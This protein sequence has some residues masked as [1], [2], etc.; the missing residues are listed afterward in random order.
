M[1]DDAEQMQRVEIFGSRAQ[2]LPVEPFGFRQLAGLMMT[3]RP[4]RAGL[5]R[6]GRRSRRSR[7]A[8]EEVLQGHDAGAVPIDP[9]LVGG[10]LVF[11]RHAPGGIA[12]QPHGGRDIA[13]ERVGAMV[14]RTPI[15]VSTAA[16]CAPRI[17]GPFIVTIGKS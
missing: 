9:M 1:A 7:H 12:A 5:S 11:D 17:N 4:D 10:H 3:D 16:V 13:V 14:S 2:D 15:I 8:L 6:G